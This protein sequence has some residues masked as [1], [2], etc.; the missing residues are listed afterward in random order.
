MNPNIHPTAIVH[1]GAKIAPTAH[2]GPYCI[3]GEDVTLE[4]GVVLVSH[5]CIS[6]VTTLGARTRVAPFSSLGGAPQST[7]YKGEKT[8]LTIGTDCDIREHV[9]ISTGTVSGGGQTIV[10]DRNMIMA[11]CHI[12]HD[13]VIGNDSIFA[14]NASFGGHCVTGDRVIMGAFAACHQ[15]IRL[16]EGA[17]IAAMA[18]IR[19]DV[20][21]YGLINR[22]G[23]L[24]GI[25]LIGLKRSGAT[26]AD[27]V[28]IRATVRSI[29]FGDELF[30]VRKQRAIQNPPENQFAAKIVTFIEAGGKR[31]ILKFGRG[32]TIGAAGSE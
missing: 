27:L 3:V 28:S 21:P 2:V 31:P 8:T 29:F 14:N 6:G 15:H 23:F 22:H 1:V 7:S 26:K 5:V 30:E 9:T 19:E 20:I 17:M 24:G 25:N 32:E 11:A 4:D 10:G 16:G 18:G 12:G 13:C